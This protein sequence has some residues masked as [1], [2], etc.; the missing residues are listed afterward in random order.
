MCLLL[1]ALMDESTVC[2]LRYLSR[3]SPI[4]SLFDASGSRTVGATG[5]AAQRSTALQVAT[6]ARPGRGGSVKREFA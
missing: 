4:D 3:V 5:A 6:F 2:S 1:F